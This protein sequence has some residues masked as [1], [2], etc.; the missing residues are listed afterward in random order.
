MSK[1]AVITEYTVKSSKL[2]KPLTIAHVS[3]L[4]ERNG[5]EFL[6]LLRQVKPDL[7]AVSGDTLERYHIAENTVISKSNN[8]L[9]KA[10]IEAAYYVNWFF[11]FVLG[12]HNRPDIKN[13]YRFIKGAPEIAP[14]VMSLGNHEG[15]LEDED[16]AVIRESGAVM[17]DNADTQLTVGGC[18]LLIGGL[19]SV[20]DTDWLQSFSEK[21]GF[22]LLLCHHPE[23]FDKIV[24]KND[25]DLT[26]SGHNHGGQIRLFGKGLFSSGSGLFPK[27]DGGLFENRIVVSAGC[28]N[29]VAMPRFKNPRELVVIR[30]TP[31]S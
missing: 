28:S 1:K 5:D 29:T 23:Y 25:I 3:D 6:E 14:T 17:L 11:V 30:L 2:D 22:K 15:K 16:H 19:S 26:L 27:Y 20:P 13:A 8:F 10:I 12:R 31:D 7:I 24:P 9:R 21:H 4:H 18:K